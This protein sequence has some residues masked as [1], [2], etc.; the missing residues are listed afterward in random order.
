MKISDVCNIVVQAVY[1]DTIMK[2]VSLSPF[3]KEEEIEQAVKEVLEEFKIYITDEYFEYLMEDG[4]SEF[5]N[6]DMEKYRIYIHH[7]E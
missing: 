5:T 2:I 6:D 1:D 3:S 4:F 7:S